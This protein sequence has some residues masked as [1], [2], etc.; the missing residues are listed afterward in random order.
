MGG[1]YVDI[2][3]SH[4]LDPDTPLEETIDV[5]AALQQ[6]RQIR[7]IGASNFAAWQVV[8]ANGIA[9][10]AGSAVD[11]LQPMYNLVKRQAEVEILPTRAMP[12]VT[13]RTGWRRQPSI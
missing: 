1:D 7:Y 8:K 5:L 4:R 2:F 13:G 11:V 3:Y 9:A 10:A 12:R 6:K